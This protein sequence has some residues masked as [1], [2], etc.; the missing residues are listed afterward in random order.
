MGECRQQKHT[1]SMKTECDYL[2]GWIKKR[3]HMQKSHPKVVNPRD[4]AG[5]CTH[6]HTKQQNNRDIAGEHT[7]TH[8]HTNPN[9]LLTRV[10]LLVTLFGDMAQLVAL[11]ATLHVHLAL[12]RIVTH[13]VTL[14]TLLCWH[15]HPYIMPVQF[16]NTSLLTI[17]SPQRPLRL[18]LKHFSVHIQINSDSCPYT[19]R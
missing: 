8:A 17:R 1:P 6:T 18:H 4:I 7:H 19:C 13:A 10:N 15:S 12:S 5:E 9:V 16:C 3:S 11:V 14:V 2:N